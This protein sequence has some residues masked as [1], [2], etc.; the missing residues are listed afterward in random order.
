MSYRI[1]ILIMLIWSCKSNKGAP[2]KLEYNDPLLIRC[3]SIKKV[4]KLDFKNG[5]KE[6]DILGTVE[7][8]EFE[9]FYW[10]F[11]LTKYQIT[12]K[13][14][15][16]PSLLEECYAESMNFEIEKKYGDDF[17]ERTMKEARAEFKK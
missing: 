15:D 11:M 1:L 5:V 14:N 13:A 6:Y 9:K 3:D 2:P 16:Q 17:I 12:I 4:A 10:N 7:M 8:S